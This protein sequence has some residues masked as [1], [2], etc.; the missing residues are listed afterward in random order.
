MHTGGQGCIRRGVRGGLK[1]EEGGWAVTPL[2]LGFPYGPRR[3]RAKNFEASILLAP[4]QIF[5]CQ[6]QT[7]QGEEGEG[8]GS[9]YGVRPFEGIPASGHEV[10]EGLSCLPQRAC[11]DGPSNGV[12]CEWNGFVQLQLLIACSALAATHPTACGGGG[13]GGRTPVGTSGCMYVCAF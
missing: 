1:G 7:L 9:S 13:G 12:M 8:G 10:H 3:R 6:P 5:G 2:L 11:R 4:K